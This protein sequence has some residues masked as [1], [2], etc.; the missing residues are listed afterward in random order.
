MSGLDFAV[1]SSRPE[2]HAAV[3]TLVLRLRIDERDGQEVHAAALNCQIRIEPQRR[4][5]LPEEEESLYELFGETGQWGRSL[6]PF[7]WTHVSTTVGG[8]TASTEVDLPVACSYDLEVAGAKY[9]HGL[10]GGEIPLVL[11]FS[12]TVFTRGDSGFCAQPVGWDC[13]AS[14]RLPVATWR[15]VMD[16]YFPN[17]AWVRLRRDTFGA[18]QAYKAR[19]AVPTF[20]QAF[21][22]LLKE[23]GEE[24]P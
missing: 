4:R 2:A 15:Q 22:Q 18:L 19:L 13:E 21:E 8:F 16:A 20:D 1:V 10:E 23:A 3:P 24:A 5:Y 11:L 9:L 14:Y 6:K 12:G 17:S 7:L